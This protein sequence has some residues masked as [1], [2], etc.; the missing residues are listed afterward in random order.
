MKI[1]PVLA[2]SYQSFREF[3]KC[4]ELKLNH[5]AYI[6]NESNLR[7]HVGVVLTIDSWWKNPNYNME[8]LEFFNISVQSRRI[9]SIKALRREVSID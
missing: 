7:G 2:E 3:I 1:T 4:N 6:S 9:S 8:F 5:F